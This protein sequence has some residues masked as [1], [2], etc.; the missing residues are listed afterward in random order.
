MTLYKKATMP[1]SI[2]IISNIYTC[3][4]CEYTE[5]VNNPTNE[6]KKCPKCEATMTFV[7]SSVESN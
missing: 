1:S 4:N 6:I 7:Y 5:I 2:V 3:S